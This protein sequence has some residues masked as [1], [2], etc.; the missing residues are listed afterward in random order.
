M[1]FVIDAQLRSR[2]AVWRS[3]RGHE[4]AHVRDLGLADKPDE[5]I[6]QYAASKGAVI[7][8]KDADF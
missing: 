7:L 5:I 6:A 1:H 4:A 8:M 3:G 2:L